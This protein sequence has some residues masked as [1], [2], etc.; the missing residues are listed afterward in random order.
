MN[1]MLGNTSSVGAVVR[2]WS[3]PTRAAWNGVPARPL[4]TMIWYPTH[5]QA[6]VTEQ[7]IA[8][9]RTGR[10][11]VDRDAP[12]VAD[13]RHPLVVVSHGTGGSAAS[14][15]WL[16]RR[17]AEAGFVV[18]AVNHHGGTAAERGGLTLPGAVLW[19]ERA[20]DLSR[21]LD[22][23]L[24]DPAFGVRIDP[25]SISVAGFSIGAYT[26]L[27]LAGARLQIDRW[28]PYCDAHGADSSLCRVPPE[29]GFG[30][31]EVWD[32]L[33]NDTL[34]I[35]SFARADLD[36]RD[37]RVRAVAAIAPVTVP[38]LDETSL[39]A[40]TAPVHVFA[41]SDDNQSTLDADVRPLVRSLPSSEL[42]IIDGA[43]HYTF[44]SEGTLAGQ[45]IARRF[46]TD[47]PGVSRRRIH[48][49]VAAEAAALFE[50]QRG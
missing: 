38:L 24:A 39:A 6:R 45:L 47:R 44:L 41:A 26:A 20:T 50:R 19:W 37:A 1:T 2:Q 49:R 34:A 35:D 21:V 15:A 32:F 46:V 42:T 18:A 7:R 23:V 25:T 48:D 31:D 33:D 16:C 43:G 5:T 4:Q 29:A 8:I 10:Y 17:L 22:R 11:A 3:D 9:F 27:A 14:I 12:R 30:I 40:V 28:R 36:Y 13:G